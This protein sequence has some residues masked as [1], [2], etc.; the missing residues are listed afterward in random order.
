[1]QYWPFAIA[2]LSIVFY[3]RSVEVRKLVVLFISTVLA[4]YGV[5]LVVSYPLLLAARVLAQHI[6]KG[7]EFSGAESI[8]I[9]WC[10]AVL[11]T[12]VLAWALGRHLRK[13]T[14]VPTTPA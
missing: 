6:R 3:F 5:Q 2:A 8:L 10:S 9:I 12:S 13:S 14:N 1:M 11:L 7:F 4:G